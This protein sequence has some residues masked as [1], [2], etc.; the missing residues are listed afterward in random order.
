LSGVTPGP[1]TRLYWEDDHC[2]EADAR[3]VAARFGAQPTVNET[4]TLRRQ[5]VQLD[6]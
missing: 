6:S 2:F 5:Q 4:M 3:V 1:A